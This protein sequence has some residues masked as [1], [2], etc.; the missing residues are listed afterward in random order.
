MHRQTALFM[1]LFS[2]ARITS[3]KSA[4]I[5]CRVLVQRHEYH[6][7]FV[8]I[9]QGILPYLKSVLTRQFY[10]YYTSSNILSASTRIFYRLKKKSISSAKMWLNLAQL[11][12]ET[13]QWFIFF[14]IKIEWSQGQKCDYHQLKNSSVA[15]A[16]YLKPTG[17]FDSKTSSLEFYV[18]G[19]QINSELGPLNLWVSREIR[20]RHS[21]SA[22]NSRS[23]LIIN[24]F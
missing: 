3:R 10:N 14:V 20:L 16:T 4:K 21:A 12:T 17:P 1:K 9:I 13:S 5:L 22:L 15:E 23:G 24:E 7:H 6:K 2:C 8:S 19:K 18:V 11:Q